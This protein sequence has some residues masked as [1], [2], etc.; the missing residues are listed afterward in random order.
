MIPFAECANPADQW[1]L[2]A[3]QEPKWIDPSPPS[4]AEYRKR[5][6]GFASIGDTA[7]EDY[8]DAS[9]SKSRSE[10]SRWSGRTVLESSRASR[11]ENFCEDFDYSG[12]S[13]DHPC[14]MIFDLRYFHEPGSAYSPCPSARGIMLSESFIVPDPWRLPT[15]SRFQ[16]L[17]ALLFLGDICKKSPSCH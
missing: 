15:S 3:A 1:R 7:K 17:S 5:R 8:R 16:C 10:G 4:C 9:Q 6:L 11:S 13:V 14:E 2:C 12:S